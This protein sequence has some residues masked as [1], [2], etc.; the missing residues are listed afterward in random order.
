MSGYEKIAE[1]LSPAILKAIT[2]DVGSEY[3]QEEQLRISLILRID[4]YK[5][6]HPYA[7]PVDVKI[8][9]MTSYGTARVKK[10]I[11][12]VPAGMQRMIKVYLTQQITLAD[13]DAAEKFSIA[14]FG[15]KLFY[16]ALWERVVKEFNGYL[17]FIIRAVKEGTKIRGGDPLYSVTVLDD[18]DVDNLYPLSSGFETM[19]QRAIWYPTTIASM[20][21]SIKNEI[22]R[23]FD[24]A[25]CG[26]GMLDFM[27]HD[28]GGR[29][30]TSGESA[31]I[32]GMAHTFN[33][34]GSD[35]VEGI[36]NA[37]FYY[38]CDMAAFSVYATEHSIQCSFGKGK[39]NALRYL[40]RQLEQVKAL[41]MPIVSIVI[42]GYDTFE[43]ASLI[44]EELNQEVK[45]CGAKVVFRPDSG[46]MMEIVPKL[47]R[48][49]EAA[50]GFTRTTAGYKKINYVGVIQGDG[51]DH[52]AIRTLLG[53]IMAM[54]YSPDCVC[55]GS[56]GA[57]LQK[58]DRDTF[59]FAQKACAILVEANGTT[60]WQGIAKDPITDPGKKSMEGFLTVARNTE[61]GE[62]QVFDLIKEE[63]P[64]QYEDLM[65]V[66][67]AYGKLY[68]ETTL[69]EIRERIAA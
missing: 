54:G 67:Y 48:M 25:Q 60:E 11:T 46:D 51:V 38:K 28:F 14:H 1:N 6:S 58:L 63:I 20:D 66:V 13:I 43:A 44:C 23:F 8:K 39:E 61:T 17:P 24:I 31:E 16:R 26:Y 12:I 45:D 21:F 18:S 36:L 2:P 10:S 62:L 55:F 56:G 29:G 34:Q 69:A 33:F 27:L 49:Q 50:F 52:M 4:S 64:V 3:S 59:K 57:L 15:R 22:K 37:N 47:L 9:G 42:D 30:V 7:Y 68:N 40:R 19:I 41:G 53:N 5:F 65:V 32:G 35:T